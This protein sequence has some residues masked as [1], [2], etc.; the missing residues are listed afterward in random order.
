M[1]PAANAGAT[2]CATVLSGELNGVI[3][4]TTP[5]GTRI[6][7]PMPI[8]HAG[9]AIKWHHLAIEALGFFARQ[10]QRLFRSSH[11]GV[12]IANREAG[13]GDYRLDEASI[14]VP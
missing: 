9:S 2:L 13:L 6:V 7:N 8:G 12:G 5:T 4:P 14:C 11:F 3:A 10:Q 1:L